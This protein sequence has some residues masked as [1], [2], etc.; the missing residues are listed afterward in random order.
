[1]CAAG[2]VLVQGIKNLLIDKLDNL[3]RLSRY[4]YHNKH[5]CDNQYLRTRSGLAHEVI[6]TSR[7]ILKDKLV[8]YGVRPPHE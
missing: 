6:H 5:D 1:M 4:T 3:E 2:R 8:A 7:V